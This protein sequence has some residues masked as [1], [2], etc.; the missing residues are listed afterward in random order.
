[1]TQGGV[2][3]GGKPRVLSGFREHILAHIMCK[4]LVIDFIQSNIVVTIDG[5]CNVIVGA[6]EAVDD[7]ADHLIFWD[8]LP[9]C[10]EL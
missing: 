2:G 10:G 6:I 8:W 7:V 4:N 1:M 3:G 9:S 5:G